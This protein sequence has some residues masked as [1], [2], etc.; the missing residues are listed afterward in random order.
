MATIILTTHTNV[1]IS[2]RHMQSSQLKVQ[3]QYGWTPI[4]LTR[5]EKN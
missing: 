4:K 1:N 2:L 3:K 5:I